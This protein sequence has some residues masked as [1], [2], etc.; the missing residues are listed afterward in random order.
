MGYKPGLYSDAIA[1]SDYNKKQLKKES[2]KK[3]AITL[4]ELG[5]Y[6]AFKEIFED[7]KLEE[8]DFSYIN[9]EGDIISNPNFIEG[10]KF[11]FILIKNGFDKEK[12]NAYVKA[13]ETIKHR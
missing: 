3:V 11:G 13:T 10:R 7:M 9:I 4:K 5:K 2:E 6:S 8:Q 12:Y 1:A